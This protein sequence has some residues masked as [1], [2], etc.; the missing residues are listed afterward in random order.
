M[1]IN[2]IMIPLLQKIVQH[3]EISTAATHERILV[4]SKEIAAFEQ[5]LLHRIAQMESQ[6]QASRVT[7]LQEEFSFLI[8][9]EPALGFAVLGGAPSHFGA[10]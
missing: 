1:G 6:L 9:T 8:D 3:L 7:E 2:I 4:V 10:Y 5:N